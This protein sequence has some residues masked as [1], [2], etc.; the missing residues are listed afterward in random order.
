MKAHKGMR[1]H[2]IPILLKIISLGNNPW[3]NK[4]LATSLQISAS[5][6][7]DSISRSE[8]AGLI[9]SDRR[10]V[11]LKEVENFLDMALNMFSLL[12]QEPY[13]LEKEQLKA[14]QLS[15]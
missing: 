2:D 9:G 11:Q 8:Y 10:T 3:M 14:R 15:D 7:S 4:D 6:I 1:P 12:N 13:S 5:E